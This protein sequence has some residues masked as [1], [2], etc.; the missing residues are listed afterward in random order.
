[1]FN[2]EKELLNAVMKKVKNTLTSDNFLADQ[3]ELEKIL[4]EQKKNNF[5]KPNFTL[6]K[7]QGR[8]IKILEKKIHPWMNLEMEL[9]DL[10]TFLEIVQ[11]ENS[12]EHVVEVQQ[13]LQEAQKKFDELEKR[14][15]FQEENDEV[16]C[17]LT[18]QAGAGGTESC[19]WAAMLYRLYNRWVEKRKFKLSVIDYQSGEEVGLKSATV[20]IEGLYAYGLLKSENGVHRLVRISPFDAN[21]KRHT[22]FVSLN[23]VAELKEDINVEIN[24]SELRIDT[25]RSSGAG[26][27]TR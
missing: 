5:S 21:K 2:E 16:N 7:E 14:F 6:I 20:L 25:Y 27:A 19:D 9:N 15:L 17:Y 18:I 23:V 3:S 11:E 13:Q 22:S 10:K 4:N 12:Q 8:K 1:M 26:G 24:P